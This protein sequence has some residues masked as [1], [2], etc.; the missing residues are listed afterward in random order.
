M[1]LYSKKHPFVGSYLHNLSNV[2][3]H[4]RASYSH[5]HPFVGSCVHNFSYAFLHIMASARIIPWWGRVYISF[6]MLSSISWPHAAATSFHPTLR[7]FL[8]LSSS[9]S[10]PPLPFLLSFP[11]LPSPLPPLYPASSSLFLLLFLLP[12]LF[13]PKSH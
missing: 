6:L 3:L 2:F 7:P 8:H 4:I 13:C 11:T 1:A 5:K 12:L 9:S 10:P